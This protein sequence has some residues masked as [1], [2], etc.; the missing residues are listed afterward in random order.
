MLV[1][2]VID[3]FIH[4]CDV[5]EKGATFYYVIIF[6]VL[7]YLAVICVFLSVFNFVDMEFTMTNT[8]IVFSLLFN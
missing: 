8:S 6:S 4:S 7:I 5:W 1:I 2:W 3:T